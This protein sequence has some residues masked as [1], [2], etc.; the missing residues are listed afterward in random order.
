[1]PRPLRNAIKDVGDPVISRIGY[2]RWKAAG[3]PLPA[4]N[5]AK[6]EIIRGYARAYGLDVLVETG[7]FYAETVRGLR[8]EFRQIYSIELDEHL[9]GMA[10]ARCKHQANAVLLQGDS[11]KR[12]GDIIARLT[13]PA[14]FWLDAHYSGGE[15]ARGDVDTPIHAELIAVL[16]DGRPHI[17]LVDDMRDFVNSAQDYP[18]LDAVRQIAQD[19]DYMMSTALDVIRFVPQ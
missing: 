7:T 9:Y 12:I 3:R 16:G 1:M 15:T 14:L 19:H 5:S 18:T 10:V 2:R 17:V 11:S 8:K 4:P 6:R 13:S